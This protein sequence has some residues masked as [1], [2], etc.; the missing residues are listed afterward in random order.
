MNFKIMLVILRVLVLSIS[1][2][3]LAKEFDFSITSGVSY[4]KGKRESMEKIDYPLSFS[5]QI[6]FT[7]WDFK[8]T[9]DVSY[10]KMKFDFSTLKSPVQEANPWH[11][12]I[13]TG[14]TKDFKWFEGYA[15]AGVSFIKKNAKLI[16]I[17]E[18]E[19]PRIRCLPPIK[20]K[21]FKNH[22]KHDTW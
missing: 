20:R 16:E 22:G 8:P 4:D 14:L 21:V 17:V 6:K 15:V 18:T 5:G 13:R 19:Q 12:S 7:R 10:R 9:L 1:T 2:N 3:I 11:L